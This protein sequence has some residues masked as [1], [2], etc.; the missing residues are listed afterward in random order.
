MHKSKRVLHFFTS[1]RSFAPWLFFAAY[2]TLGWQIIPDY[3]VSWDEFL[4]RRYGLFSYDHVIRTLGLSWDLYFPDYQ[5]ETSAG[6]QYT[7]IFSLIAAALEKL[8]NIAPEDHHAQFLLR[9][10]MVFL[11]FW[12]STIFFYKILKERFPKNKGT[13]SFHFFP[14]AG[15]LLFILTPR[16]FA[17]AFFNPK[18]I[19]L[20]S[21]YII[22]LYTL[23]RFCKNP[24][25]LTGL[26]HGIAC[27]FVVNARTP[28]L[29]VPILTVC[30]LLIWWLAA[31][32]P[33]KRP[34]LKSLIPGTSAFALA[35]LVFGIAFYPYLWNNM[36]THMTESFELMSR[37]PK[38]VSILMFGTYVTGTPPP[39]YYPYAWMG[40]TLPLI[41][42][43]LMF[44]GVMWFAGKFA[45]RSLTLTFWKNRF[46]IWDL[47]F[48][49]F[50]IGPL[51]AVWIFKSTLYDGWRH[52]YFIYPPALIL[53]LVPLY[54]FLQIRKKWLRV[55]TFVI[56]GLSCLY[57]ALQ[58][59]KL[60]PHQ[61]VYFN[62]LAGTKKMER[63]EM[64]Y[65]GVA[66][67]QAFE[68][69][70]ERDTT[71]A[72]IH[73]FCA[74]QPCF[75]NYFALPEETK[76]K[77][78]MRYGIEVAT[79]F[80]SNFRW[81]HEMDKFCNGEFPYVDEYFSITADGER[82]IGVYRIK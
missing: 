42:L 20:L 77:I 26:W 31:P 62:E 58:M 46:H 36:E 37:F 25:L 32:S 12:L 55:V 13:A 50:F 38:E 70:V 4:Q 71:G 54:H 67:K 80:L 51:L 3:G 28:G 6:R 76:S 65:W 9:H 39:L 41:N 35:F 18:D 47:I 1:S 14:L 24:T 63:F 53:G 60:H 16:I 27:A 45:L 82:I 64:D 75:D 74:N 79:F 48:F 7:V 59:V 61:Q 10:R 33:Q 44:I 22:S 43:L 56:I 8:F 29:I 23:L 2:F 34:P 19:V 69:L 49:S 15:T 73:V 17:H 72:P 11:L 78:K 66:Y 81:E 30:F 52:L 57:T 40:I 21:F 68:A 5:L